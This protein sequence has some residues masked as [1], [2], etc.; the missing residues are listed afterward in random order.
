MSEPKAQ[1]VDPQGNMNLPGMNATGVITASSFSGAG[2]V[3]TGLTGSPN[4][5]VGVVTATSFV[6]DGTGHAANLTGTPNLNLGLTTATSFVG[7]A[8]GKAAG[9]TG[10]PNLNVGLI[11]ATGFTGDVKGAVTGN[12][13]GNVT[14]NITGDVTGN[15]TGDVTGNITGNIG[16][17]VEGDVTGNVSGLARG[18]GISGKG[19]WAGAGTSNVNVG[20]VTAVQYYGDGSGLTGA[21]S[22]ATKSQVITASGD[23]TI[24]DLSDGNQI[25]LNQTVSNTTVGFASTSAAEQITI[26]RNTNTSGTEAWNVGLANTGAVNFDGVGDKISLSS[27]SSLQ[28]G[29]STFQIEFWV[30]KNAETPDDYDVWCSKGSNN[31]NTREFAL[32]SYADGTLWWF[33]SLTGSSWNSYFQVSE[34]IPVQQWTQI[35]AQKFAGYF[36]FYVD[37]QRT[38]HN[39]D[40]TEA[41]HEAGG[42]FC[43]GGFEDANNVYE[44]NVKISNFRFINNPQGTYP[45]GAG[46]VGSEFIP[47][48]PPLQPD[49]Q[50][51]VLA[52]QSTSSVTAAAVAPTT[53]SS[54][55][56]PSADTVTISASGSVAVS[57]YTM[58]WP[59]TIKWNGG[60]APTLFS[61][62]R[63]GA[64]QIFRLTTADT[65]ANYQGW[66]EMKSDT[67]TLALFMWGKNG[68]GGLGQNDT[69]Q[70]SSPTQVGTDATWKTIGG[71]AD[72]AYGGRFAIKSDNTL[73]AWGRNYRNALGLNDNT[74]Y[75]SPMQIPGEWSSITGTTASHATKTDGTL[76]SWGYGNVSGAQGQNDNTGRNSPKQVGTDTDWSHVGKSGGLVQGI[77]TDG[78]LW[79][80]GTS[81]G[82][83]LGLNQ[84]P[85]NNRSSP[86]QLPGSWSKAFDCSDYCAG[87]KTDGTYWGWASNNNGNLGQN[88]RTNQSS[89]VQI[90]GTWSDVAGAY[91]ANGGV[92]TDG[93]LWA[94]GDNE[95]GMLGL[96]NQTE[97][98][99][100]TQ[101]PGTTWRSID[102]GYGWT[103]ATKT[104]NTMWSWGLSSNGRLGL[105]QGPSTNR[106]SPTQVPGLWASGATIGP[107]QA[108]GNTMAMKLA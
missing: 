29:N 19:V 59:N 47:V 66:E 108:Q 8:V 40:K 99:S 36:S 63:S 16:G 70:R 71:T 51:I 85:G 42:D 90:P 37:G 20:V 67:D 82:G 75:S 83:R 44:S 60:S 22:S 76:W 97:Y 33:Y 78:T 64:F 18:L 102:M 49:A 7:D 84:G 96:N 41:Y 38:Y 25:Y 11:T 93:T 35:V 46:Y 103:I 88:D 50:T 31:N 34:A 30:Y 98:S 9:L 87:L 24:I 107:E 106:S 17:D 2:G 73:W 43:I 5:N 68:N 58:E 21:G 72:Y 45:D 53:F 86:I 101:I 92:K 100:P 6:G 15:I 54:T 14:G 23:E 69:V 91:N 95:N 26:I 79:M 81:S 77:K 48:N 27:S 3:V 61:N 4:L 39:S 65:G 32:E 52:C 55:G 62:P 56:D 10:T 94:W 105:N 12:I 13:T 104:D 89:P 28:I 74:S 80:A 57:D 1:L